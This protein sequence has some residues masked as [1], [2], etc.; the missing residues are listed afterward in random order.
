M[1]NDS[2]T[3]VVTVTRK[4]LDIAQ[5]TIPYLKERTDRPFHYAVVANEDLESGEWLMDNRNKGW[6]D[7]VAVVSENLGVGPGYNLFWRH[8]HRFNREFKYYVKMDDS[9]TP[10][11]ADWLTELIRLAD[12]FKGRIGMA[13]YLIEGNDKEFPVQTIE[14]WRVRPTPTNCSGTCCLI[15]RWVWEQVG[16]WDEEVIG[17]TGQERE[18]G[19]IYYSRE[20]GIMG[21]L[22]GIMNLQN[23]YHEDLT[24]IRC[25]REK[26]AAPYTQ[27]KERQYA[28]SL[29]PQ[30]AMTNEYKLH[31]R[32]LPH[33]PPI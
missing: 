21:R 23:M 25:L 6:F 13:A 16:F 19:P 5:Q 20:D 18:V 33:R 31:K 12:Y 17:W 7:S 30:N 3:L 24:A 4:N 22:C 32:T 1:T 11:R 28:M 10:T 27:W 14:G 29:P 8:F 15:P 2:D 26:H 9:N